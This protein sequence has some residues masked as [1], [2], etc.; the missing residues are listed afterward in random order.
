MAELDELTERLQALT[1]EYEPPPFSPRGLVGLLEKTLARLPQNM[2]FDILQ[3]ARDALGGGTL[4]VEVLKGAWYMLNYTVQYNAGLVKRHFS[5]EYD[6]DEWGMDWEIVDALRPLFNFLYKGYWRVETSGVDHIPVEGRALLVSNH[7]GML[8]WDSMM[9]S[10]AV[11]A[12][13]PAQRPVRTLHDAWF[14]RLP[15]VSIGLARLGLVLAS[16]ENGVRLLEQEAVVAV[17]PE[18]YEGA[19]KPYKD[20][21]HLGRFGNGDFVKMALKTQSPII[22]VSV[23]GAE[24]TYITLTR[25]RRLARIAGLPYFPITPAFPWLGLLGLVPLPSKWY[26]DF[27]EPLPMDRY[28]PDAASNL[29]L[30]AQLSDQVRHTI[31]QMLHSRLAQRSS[32]FL[33][34]DAGRA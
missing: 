32:I 14:S 19:G 21:Y 16:M 20:R 10:T 8:P 34:R 22:P 5:G 18:G 11:L 25:S 17:Y 23:V 9:V 4:D 1:P 30:V 28:D 3:Q 13:H 6:T 7:S 31:Q 15:F 24:E 12:E 29:V 27:G 26:I 2:Q 33:G